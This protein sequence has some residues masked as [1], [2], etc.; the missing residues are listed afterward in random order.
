MLS[1]I[2]GVQFCLISNSGIGICNCKFHSSPK[3]YDTIFINHF[4][5]SNKMDYKHVKNIKF[6]KIYNSQYKNGTIN[7]RIT[8]AEGQSQ[9]RTC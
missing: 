6:F 8:A 4:L 9:C 1:E 2:S 7:V 3:L 5:N